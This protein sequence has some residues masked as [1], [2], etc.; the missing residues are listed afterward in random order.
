[1]LPEGP[2]FGSI[3]GLT[4]RET[5]VLCEF[6]GKIRKETMRPGGGLSL[7]MPAEAGEEFT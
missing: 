1:M 3:K 7:H 6:A 2:I 4:R 5:G